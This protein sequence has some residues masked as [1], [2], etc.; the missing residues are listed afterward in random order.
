MAGRAL[1]RAEQTVRRQVKGAGAGNEEPVAPDELHR[2]LVQA[3][4]SRLP[5]RNVFL[6]LDEGGR[7]DHDYVEA[8]TLLVQRLQHVEAVAVH[9]LGLEGVRSRVA[10]QPLQ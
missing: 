5:F 4:V 2:E 7:I 3:T 8:P 9:D 10:L 6:A 1:N